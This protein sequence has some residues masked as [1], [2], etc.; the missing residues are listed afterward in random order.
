MAGGRWF[1]RMFMAILVVALLFAIGAGLYRG[2]WNQGYLMGQLAGQGD[3]GALPPMAMYG[4]PGPGFGAGP[5]LILLAL[6]VAGLLGGMFMF[7]AR[8]AAAGPVGG[9]WMQHGHWKHG[10][11]H[12]PHPCGDRPDAEPEANRPAEEGAGEVAPQ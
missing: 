5:G 8:R 7:G 11:Q 9:P 10:W 3:G 4:Y 1:G 6:L 2:G 12:G